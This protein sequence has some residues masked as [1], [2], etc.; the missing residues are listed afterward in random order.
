MIAQALIDAIKELVDD[1]PVILVGYSA[2]GF[3]ALRMAARN[4]E[5][6]ADVIRISGLA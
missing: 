2:R 3:A 6:A 4:P 1:Q 5:I